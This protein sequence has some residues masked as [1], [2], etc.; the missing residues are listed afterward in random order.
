MKAIVLSEYGP[1]DILEL[2][3]A[4]E[5]QPTSRTATASSKVTFTGG[6][7]TS[8]R[9]SPPTWRPHSDLAGRLRSVGERS[10]RLVQDPIERKANLQQPVA[11]QHLLSRLLRLE[12][13]LPK[14]CFLV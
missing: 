5:P 8:A 13:R 2:R 9:R 12:Q 4:S 1:S 14:R 3:T 11:Y 7:Q 10:V 6:S